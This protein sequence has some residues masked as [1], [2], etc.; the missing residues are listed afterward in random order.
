MSEASLVLPS[1]PA[2]LGLRDSGASRAQ[3]PPG[4]TP[5]RRPSGRFW[6]LPESGLSRPSQRL[7]QLGILKDCVWHGLCRRKTFQKAVCCIQYMSE[8]LKGHQLVRGILTTVRVCWLE[9]TF[10]K[11][12]ATWS[13]EAEQFW[14]PPARGGVGGQRVREDSRE[15]LEF[16]ETVWPHGRQVA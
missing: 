5:H 6:A 4:R 10:S 9:A 13:L 2:A 3:C 1:V 8:W 11:R 15:N 12:K 16:L 14:G 7:A